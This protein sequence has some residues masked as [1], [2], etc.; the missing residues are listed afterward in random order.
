MEISPEQ[1]DKFRA[2]YRSKFGIELT[3][4]EALEK[5]TQLLRLMQITYQP[6]TEADHDRVRTRRETLL[7]LK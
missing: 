6:I 7:N 4:Q 5:A 3:P 1:L 2:I